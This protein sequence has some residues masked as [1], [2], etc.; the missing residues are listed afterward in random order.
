MIDKNSLTNLVKY[1]TLTLLYSLT[2]SLNP[3]YTVAFFSLKR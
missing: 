2:H 1:V 3:L